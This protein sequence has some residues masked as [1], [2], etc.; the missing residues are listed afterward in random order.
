MTPLLLSSQF[1]E[2]D[3]A[4]LAAL[5][6]ELGYEGLDLAVT[7]RPGP[8]SGELIAQLA[9]AGAP[10]GLLT[11]DEADPDTV[12]DWAAL[13]ATAGCAALRTAPWPD[14]EP[15]RRLCELA[16]AGRQHGVQVLVPNQSGSG[17]REPAALVEHLA[18]YDP[19]CL[20]AALAPDQ[21]PRWRDSDPAAWLAA[22][23]LPPLGC[24]VLANY[25]W[26]SEV[27]AGNVRVWSTRAAP[28]AQGLTCWPAWFDRLAHDGFDG[29]ITFGDPSLAATMADRL[30][31]AR[32]DLRFVRR[33][34]ERRSHRGV[35]LDA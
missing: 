3:P 10:V 14:D 11:L 6:L 23:T 16:A 20:A 29:L 22:Q 33:T 13:A 12:E 32:D 2:S 24:V 28:A 7:G 34:W 35:V 8:G 4:E 26:T 25:R 5:A 30:R 21:V 19:S 17:L 18:A 15:L 1:P 9:A 27:G 31:L